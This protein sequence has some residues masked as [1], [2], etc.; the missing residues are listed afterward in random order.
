M[1]LARRA[2]RFASLTAG[3]PAE[4]DE[5]SDEEQAQSLLSHLRDWHRREAKAPWWEFFR[6]RDLTEEELLDERAAVGGLCFVTN[7]ESTKRGLPIDR[8]SYPL[9]ETDIQRGDELHLPDGTNF[10]SVEA[11]NRVERTLDVN[12]SGA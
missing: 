9:Q 8:Y 12:K 6:L 3:I 5:R 4:W 10:G 11:I 7:V 2:G 1:L